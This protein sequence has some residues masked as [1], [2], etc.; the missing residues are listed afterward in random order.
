MLSG[1]RAVADFT[2]RI[3]IMII[4]VVEGNYRN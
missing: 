1:A 4:K 2:G 3:K